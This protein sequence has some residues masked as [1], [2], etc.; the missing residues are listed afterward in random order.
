MWYPGKKGKIEPKVGDVVLLVDEALPP[1]FWSLG[2]IVGLFVGSDG[3]SRFA[4]LKT[5]HGF[6]GRPLFKLRFLE[7]GVTNEYINS[8]PSKIQADAGSIPVQDASRIRR[9]AATKMLKRLQQWQ[10]NDLV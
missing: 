9:A 4:R 1:S 2:K 7:N 6:V 8:M 3:E 10:E 5:K